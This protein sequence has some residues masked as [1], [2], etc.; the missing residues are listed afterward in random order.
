[1]NCA[2]LHFLLACSVANAGDTTITLKQP[3]TWQAG[4]HI[5][6]AT[7]GDR[8]SQ[9]ENEENYIAA[10]SGDGY[11]IT[12]KNPLKYLHISIEQTFGDRTVETRGEVAL[13]SRNVVIKG[14]MNEQFVETL[15][16]CEEE[17]NSGGAFSDAMQT[18]FAGKFG[19]ELGS[20]EMGAV[21]IISPKYKNQNLVEARISYTEL[22]S[23]GQAFRVGRYPIHFHVTGAMNTSYVRGNAIHHSNNRA[24]TLHDISNTTVEHNVAYNIKGLTFFLE[25]GV[26]MYNVIQYNL[27]IFTRMSNSLLNPDI[28]PASF[29]IV[30]PNNKF[31]HN[32][33]AGGTHLCFWLRPARVPDGPSYTQNFCPYRVPFDEFHNNTAHSMGWYGFWIFGQSNHVDYDPHTGTPERGYCDGHRTQARIGSFTTWN[34]KRG[35]EIVAG[36]NI[37]LENQTHMDHD[38]SAFEIFKAKGP[39]GTDGPGI[40]NT[41]IVGSSKISEMIP[42]REHHCTPSGA[43]IPGG[44]TLE[45]VKFYNFGTKCSAISQRLEEKGESANPARTIGL[46]FENTTNRVYME[47]GYTNAFWFKDVDGSLT[48]KPDS[49]LVTKTATNPQELCVDDETDGL[50]KG[51]PDMLSKVNAWGEPEDG[52][53]GS[54]CDKSATF[55]KVFIDNPAPTSLKYV[56]LSITN[57]WGVSMR[58]WLH[59]AEGWMALLPQDPSPNLLAFQ[60]VE[61]VTNISYEFE[62]YGMHKGENYLLMGHDLYQDPDRFTIVDNKETN[63]SS[64]LAEMPT[65]ATAENGEWFF[66]NNTGTPYSKIVYLLSSKG[67]G[68]QNWWKKREAEETERTGDDGNWPENGV[69]TGYFKVIRC[70]SEG[71]IPLPPPT[72]PTMRPEN[73]LRWSNDSHWESLGMLAPSTNEVVQIPGGVW[74]ILDVDPPKLKRLFIYGAL[75]VEDT[76]DRVIESELVLIQG[77]SFIVGR[78][79]A[80]FTHKFDLILHGNHLTEDQPM[81]DAPNCGAKALCVYGTS[82]RDSPI[83]GFVD[84]HGIDVGKSWVKL[85]KTANVG[86][87]SIELTEAVSWEANSEIVLSATSWE[88]KETEKAVIASVS[89]NIITLAQPLQFKHLSS[90][91]SLT[92]QAFTFY[93]QAE[94]GLL[95]R[96]V[97]IIGKDYPEQEEEQFGARVL[98]AAFDKFGTILPGYGRFSNV[99]FVRGGQEGWSDNYDPRYTLAFMNSGDHE[100]AAGAP[101]AKESYV[102]NC[103][104]NYNY[105][106]AIG[107]F[108][109]NNVGIENNVIFR[110]ISSG[111]LDESKGTK[112]IR[113]LVM[114]GESIDHFKNLL[115]SMEF[116]GCIDIKRADEPIFTDNVMAG[117]AQAGLITRGSPCTNT[118]TWKNNE[119]H[120]AQHGIHLNNRNWFAEECVYVKNFYAWRNFD[121]GFMSLTTD[122]IEL[123]DNVL[124]DNGVGVMNHGTG[125]SADQHIINEDLHVTIKNTVIVANSDLYDCADDKLPYTYKFDVHKKR[126]WSERFNALEGKFH[127]TGV[128]MPLFMSK[129]P[130]ETMPWHQAMKGAE[131]ANPSLR[132]IMYMTNVTFDKF[133]NRCNGYK[134]IVIR[135][136][137]KDD[138]VNF[139][140]KMK[141]IKLLDVAAESKVFFN[142]PLAGKINP[143]DCSDFDCDGMKKALIWDTDGTFK[144]QAG[145]I[146][147]DSAYEWDGSPKRGLGYYRVPKPM[148]T[149]LN[150]DRIPYASKMPNTGIYRGDKCTWN[151]DWVAYSCSGLNHRIM[152]IESMD[153]DTKIRRLSPIAMLADPGQNGFIDLVNGPQDHSCCSGYTCAERLSTFYTMVA[154]GLEYEVMMTSIPPQNF[155][156]H[157]LYNDG[158][159][160]VRVKMW[161]PKQQRLDVYTEG[162]YIPPMNKDFSVTDGHKLKPA[163]DMFIPSLADNNCNNYFDPNTGHLYLI[164]QGP[165]TCDI[166]T[167][168]VVVL[169]LGITVNEDEFFDADSIVGNIAGL[170][171]IP[172]ANIRVTNIVR[173]GSVRRRKRAA[174]Q[175]NLQFEIAPAPADELNEQEFVPEVATYTT[176]ADPNEATL[177]PSYTTTTTTTAR[178]LPVVDPLAMDFNALS[179]IQSKIATSFQKGDL[180]SALN[181]T[182]SQMKMEDPIPPP[183]EPPAYTSP[184]ERGQ[185]LETTYAEQ[186]AKK[187]EEQLKSLTEE[188]NY[189]VPTNLVLGRQPYE[190]AE[191]T[192]L[193]FFPYLYVT[194]ANNTQLTV[195]GNDADPWRVTANLKA[196]PAGAT[197]Q[198]TLTVPITGGFANFTNLF[199]SNEGTAYQLTF[200]LTYPDVDIASV[201]SITF[202][203]GPRPLGVRFDMIDSL[204]PNADV[205]NATFN[206]WDEGQDI[207]ATPQVLGTQTWE[208]SLAF[209]RTVPIKL[210]GSTNHDILQAGSSAGVFAIRFEGSAVNI[211]FVATCSSPE[212]GRTVTGTSNSF[213]VFPGASSSVGLLRKTS[214]G[215]KYDGPYE[216]IKP[217]VDA[218]NTELGTLECDGC[219]APSSR[220]RRESFAPTSQGLLDLSQVS[221]CSMPMCVAQDMS[222]VC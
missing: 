126:K 17:F 83:P 33:C 157:M 150:G 153:R 116:Y 185:V 186:V 204:V 61:H 85:G 162:R 7:T 179:E 100:D 91:S 102:K 216:V 139:P 221:M 111:I 132:G 117:C 88:Y 120:T 142:R 72:V 6:I 34:N 148:V 188:K 215:L 30:N 105:N 28:N 46:S 167:Q 104:L 13:L 38:F 81:Y 166:K 114:M 74:M 183:E 106:S 208:C 24:C 68:L 178:P 53:T 172:A 16:A 14:T 10:I 98:V 71:C 214:I 63:S 12:L 101:A 44:Y 67:N 5:A 131:G 3:V 200:S 209:S 138:D 137:P 8:N 196:G 36:A 211:Q 197:S 59:M 207:A 152:I 169:K 140:I 121:Y 23:V 96:S 195:V 176:P 220:K 1:M 164:V 124:V 80:P 146:I 92:G 50:G 159:D 174:E 165:A 9:K 65:Y 95:T 18:C 49:H 15:P 54:I 78:E 32:S 199:M 149:E 125:P 62:V 87:T 156:F 75:E 35:F 82:A 161:F 184:E 41:I 94:V 212:S 107:I 93:Q 2:L 203:V 25:D 57:K 103:G 136:N 118:Y 22:T 128:V 109:S 58:P 66:S 143:A 158:G 170:L 90:S 155:K 130:K 115:N 144:G 86:D 47:K 60:S 202:N 141:Q 108:G 217:V 145:T 210:V 168:P 110:H 112:I 222:C 133:D 4:D 193:I 181:V 89:G 160:A 180:S 31:R 73:A 201:D 205:L 97:R 127:H 198:G 147:A 119:I 135:T 177:K 76:E 182:V 192:P 45:N 43:N 191:M 51:T 129:Y 99:E 52:E 64:S 37:R 29:W 48:G 69:A 163:D 171:G 219:P 56:D 55:H 189:D 206:I 79:D 77:G 11:T 218:F 26:E 42:G 213:I 123:E 134:D 173:E 190:A 40:F 84:M 151:P 27:A 175:L 122:S 39:Y 19:E 187:G 194:N 113:N 154:T 21:I 20:D 70:E